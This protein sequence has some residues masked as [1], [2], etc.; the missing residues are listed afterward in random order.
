MVMWSK[1]VNGGQRHK[2]DGHIKQMALLNQKVLSHRGNHFPNISQPL[3]RHIKLKEQ[4]RETH[5][6]DTKRNSKF[7]SC[8]LCANSF[9]LAHKLNL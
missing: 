7:I 2:I 6:R 8:Q 4:P 3:H 9:L 5:E 1:Q